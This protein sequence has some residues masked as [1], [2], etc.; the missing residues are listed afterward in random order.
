TEIVGGESAIS[1][2]M[3]SDNSVRT[4][5]KGAE[6]IHAFGNFPN[7]A[8]ST[9]GKFAAAARNNYETP[10]EIWAGPIGEWRQLTKNNTALFSS[11][12]KAQNLEWTN[13]G[14]N[15]QGWLVPPKQIKPGKKCPMVVIIHGGPSSA[16]SEERRVGRDVMTS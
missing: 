13:E 10:P 12:G 7:F 15:I 11:W 14:L 3:L 2:L 6:H 4:I 5:W 1:E 16:R 9:D 8:L